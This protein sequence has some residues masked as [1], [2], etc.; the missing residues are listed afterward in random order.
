MDL[1]ARQRQTDRQESAV[2]DHHIANH[3]T[4]NNIMENMA[5]MLKLPVLVIKR[6]GDPEQLSKDWE[7]YV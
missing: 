5:M 1:C 7:E 2:Q 3:R 6:K 4:Q